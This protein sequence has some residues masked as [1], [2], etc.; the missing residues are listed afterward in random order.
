MTEAYIRAER[1]CSMESALALLELK[2]PVDEVASYTQLSVEEVEQ[3]KLTGDLPED[4][5]NLNVLH[6]GLDE[7]ESAKLRSRMKYLTDQ[8]SN[9]ATA[10]DNGAKIASLAAAKKLLEM[11]LPCDQIA[12]VTMLTLEE[13]ERLR[14]EKDA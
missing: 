10:W 14:I 1:K 13:V 6:C 11:D 5:R 2:L 8:Q 9:L 3:L 4:I 7:N 12:T